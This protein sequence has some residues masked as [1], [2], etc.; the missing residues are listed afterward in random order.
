M[1]LIVLLVYVS[2]MA[3]GAYKTANDMRGKPEG[4]ALDEGVTSEKFK[5]SVQEGYRDKELETIV[6]RLD[7]LEAMAGQ[8]DRMEAIAGRL[9]ALEGWLGGWNV[10]SRA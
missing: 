2:I 7:A 1:A 9:G 10:S 4:V 5:E 3:F 6:D 8:L